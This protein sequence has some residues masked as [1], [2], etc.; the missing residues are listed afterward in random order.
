MTT[1]DLTLMSALLQKM[2]WTE[3]R[4]QVLSQNI[5]NADTPGY[6]PQDI[7][8]LDF[9]GLLSH[10]TSTLSLTSVGGGSPG[11]TT[12][13]PMHLTASGTTAGGDMTKAKNSKN[14]YETAPAGN[15][16]VLEEQLLKMNSNYA[17]HSFA[18][19]LYMRNMQML[20]SS[21]KSS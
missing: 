8:P 18:S 2:D 15:S 11:L 3:H 16:V 21:I 17:D 14:N 1:Q 19:N 10:S 13:N 5:A 4:Q 9:K 6:K 12:T 20:K 7:Q